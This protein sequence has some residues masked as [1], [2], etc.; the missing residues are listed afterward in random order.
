MFIK[1]ILFFAGLGYISIV[2][3]AKVSIV[4]IKQL[5]EFNALNV[6]KSQKR[7]CAKLFGVD[8]FYHDFWNI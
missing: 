7:L 2:S 4:K 6:P 1:G 5:L 3:I 8:E